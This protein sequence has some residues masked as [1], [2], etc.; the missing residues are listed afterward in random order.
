MRVLITGGAGFIGANLARRLLGDGHDVVVL[1]DLST[2]NRENLAG[3]EVEFVEGSILDAG[4]LDQVMA[5]TDSVVH[6]AAR[7]SVPRSIAD[8]MASHQANAT[9]TARCSRPSAGPAPAGI[10][11]R[12]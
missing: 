4:A 12:T 10:G 8:P 11:R 2:G 5:G 9:G 6:L 1:D 7:P 3:V